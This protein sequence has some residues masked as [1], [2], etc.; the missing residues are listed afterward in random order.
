MVEQVF[1]LMGEVWSMHNADTHCTLEGREGPKGR[2]NFLCLKFSCLAIKY[3]F[4]FTQCSVALV[5]GVHSSVY[6]LSL[7]LLLLNN[8]GSLEREVFT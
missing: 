2:E 3:E 5:G 8:T 4:Y 7:S 6:F 1:L